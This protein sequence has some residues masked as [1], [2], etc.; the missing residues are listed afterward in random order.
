VKT[1]VYVNRL[2]AIRLLG[3]ARIGL[4]HPPLILVCASATGCF[5]GRG[6]GFLDERT[7]PGAGFLPEVW[8]AWEAAT[9]AAPHP[10]KR[11]IGKG[12]TLR[13]PPAAYRGMANCGW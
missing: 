10:G 7:G 3:D 9:G 4:S 8:P 13:L 6:D 5:G 2:D 12:T 11:R 1:G